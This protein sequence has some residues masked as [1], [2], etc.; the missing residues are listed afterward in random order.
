MLRRSSG[1][2][3]CK[4]RSGVRKTDLSLAGGL[5]GPNASKQIDLLLLPSDDRRLLLKFL[6]PLA[7]ATASV[8]AVTFA[9]K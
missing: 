4:R 2:K 6:R 1:E 7:L 3:Q 9:G 8:A 5:A